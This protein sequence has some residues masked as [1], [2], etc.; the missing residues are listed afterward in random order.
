MLVEDCCANIPAFT[1]VVDIVDAAS[2]HVYVGLGP[3]Y[4]NREAASFDE[5]LSE[6]STQDTAKLP[7]QTIGISNDAI[8][9]GDVL[10]NESAVLAVVKARLAHN[11]GTDLV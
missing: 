3:G 8:R 11:M 5:G 4:S 1:R 10:L 6:G 7:R 2:T 9:G